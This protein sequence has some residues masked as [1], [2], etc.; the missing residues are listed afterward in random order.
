MGIAR[1]SLRCKDPKGRAPIAK[2]IRV[3]VRRHSRSRRRLAEPAD[4]GAVF[5]AMFPGG[6]TFSAALTPDGKRQIWEIEGEASFNALDALPVAL[7]VSFTLRPRRDSNP[8]TG[9]LCGEEKQRLRMITQGWPGGMS[10]PVTPGSRVSRLFGQRLG[11][12][13]ANQP[14]MRT[15]A[16]IT[17]HGSRP[18]RPRDEFRRR[19]GLRRRYEPRKARPKRHVQAA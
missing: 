6:L 8:E 16:R 4:L 17:D 19:A 9:R 13:E 2:F 5:R 15:R 14:Q 7:P 1:S 18:R 11:N 10:R 12:K 3:R